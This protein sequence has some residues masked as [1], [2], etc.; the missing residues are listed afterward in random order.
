MFSLR[1]FTIIIVYIALI[2]NQKIDRMEKKMYK[3]AIYIEIK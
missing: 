3:T 1:N 2:V